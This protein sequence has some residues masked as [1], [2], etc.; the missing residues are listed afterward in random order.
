MIPSG[1]TC[2]V[3]S[4]AQALHACAS[5]GFDSRADRLGAINQ[6]SQLPALLA[7]CRVIDTGSS[8][9]TPSVELEA[10]TAVL[11]LSY[12]ASEVSRKHTH[13]DQFP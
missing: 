10:N 1:V 12:D 6:L 11:A 9:L 8:V 7:S 3:S 4:P 5:L 13:K 2:G